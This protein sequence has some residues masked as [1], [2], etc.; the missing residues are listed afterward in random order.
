MLTLARSIDTMIDP[1]RDFAHKY[2]A[3]VWDLAARL[4][5]ANAFFK[6][7]LT[8]WHDWAA[9]NFAAQISLFRDE[10][11]VPGV[12]PEF[13]AYASLIGEMILPVLLA[14]G[15]FGRFAAGGLLVITLVIEFA[16]ENF[17]WGFK[18]HI[19]WA[20]LTAAILLRGPGALSIDFLI[21]RYLL[22]TG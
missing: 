14:F 1:L 4:F 20:F 22:R 17:A 8:R 2:A 12:P 11:L 16:T 18:D 13:A 19:I 10:T 6:S 9:G 3:P 21:R 15:L 5:V 7:G